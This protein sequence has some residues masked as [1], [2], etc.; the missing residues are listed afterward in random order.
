MKRFAAVG[1]TLAL[2]LSG[3]ASAQ[4]A[5]GPGVGLQGDQPMDASSE[6]F[7]RVESR[8]LLVMTGAVEIVQGQNRLRAPRLDIYY[9]QGA[10]SG[11]SRCADDVDRIVAQGPVFYVTPTQNARGNAATFDGD[12]ETI[13]MT[14]DVVL[15]QGR[16]V[17]TGNRLVF[18]TRTNDARM[19]SGGGS[20]R[21][22]AVIFPNSTN[23]PGAQRPAAGR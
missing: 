9:K 21:V 16:D 18:N 6:S 8:C 12:A 5:P 3:A 15:T 4:P 23:R 17:L 2:G 22:R 1:L 14:G 7:E 19:E 20:G 13:T 10:G 11:Q